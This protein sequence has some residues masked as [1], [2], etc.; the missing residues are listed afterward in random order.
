MNNNHMRIIK[1][2]TLLILLP[3]VAACSTPVHKDFLQA[4]TRDNQGAD[5]SVSSP[6][7]SLKYNDKESLLVVG[8]E[9]GNIDIWDTRKAQSKREIKAH[10]YPAN[11]LTFSSDGD[12]FFSSSYFEN[13]TKLWDVKT[14][15]L[16]HFVRNTRGP[17]GTTPNK[18]V[19]VIANGDHLRLFDYRQK[20]LLAEKYMCGGSITT[21]ATDASSGLIAVGNEYGS[22]DV[23]KYSENKGVPALKK[24]SG[25]KPYQFG[26]WVVGL[27]FSANGS[28][29][30]SVSRFGSIDEWASGTLEKRRSV[31]TVLK[32]VYSTSFFRDKD[33]LAL[34]GTE[35]KVGT[36][37]GSVE[38][39]SLATG[40]SRKYPVNTNLAVVEFLP[41]ISSLIAVQSKSTNVF[42][43]PHEK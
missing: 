26:D 1:W 25:I 43:L 8:H 16:L 35:E 17:V 36:S 6:I 40:E 7:I 11:S 3:F 37:P 41:P 12:V 39:I 32:Y 4:F 20:L 31:P 34:A 15:D 33:I 28:S 14:G 19:Y 27:Q 22:I 9:S 30:Y 24:V 42:T 21:I 2:A 29:L 38:V 5:G 10:K 23:W 13:S 18:Q